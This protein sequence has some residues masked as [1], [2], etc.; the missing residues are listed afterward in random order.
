M[1][2]SH[3]LL[4]LGALLGGVHLAIRDDGTVADYESQEYDLQGLKCRSALGQQTLTVPH[5]LT[6]LPFSPTSPPTPQL[7]F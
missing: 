5:T 3:S 1:K 4:A 2:L 7:R 6:A